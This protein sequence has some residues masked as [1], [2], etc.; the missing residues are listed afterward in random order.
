MDILGQIP[1]GHFHVACS[2]GS[3][4]MVLVDFLRRFP[5]NQFDLLHFNHGTPCCQQAED[6]V[7]EFA[8]KAGL[9]VHLGHMQCPQLACE[10]R[11]EYWRRCRY[12]FLS[13]YGT[14][15]ILMAH[16]LDDCIETWV[17]T[18]LRGN[19]MLIPYCNPRYNV[20]RPLLTVPKSEIAAWAERNRVQWVLD[21]SNMDTSIDRNYIRHQMMD[22]IR[23]INPGIE[24]TIAR[25]VRAEY[26]AQISLDR[27]QS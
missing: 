7:V 4:S 8:R 14:E 26:Q 22:S 3:D 1:R 19:P 9:E 6:F 16:H 20:I 27:G 11:E 18:S 17:M 24:K 2:G 25:K 5:K 15:P 13:D 23:R 10:S 12:G 21:Q